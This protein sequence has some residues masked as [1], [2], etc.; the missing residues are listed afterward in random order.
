MEIRIVLDDCTWQAAF[1][2]RKHIVHKYSLSH[3]HRRLTRPLY[4]HTVLRH[5]D[6]IKFRIVIVDYRCLDAGKSARISS[7]TNCHRLKRRYYFVWTQRS[8]VRQRSIQF[9]YLFT[10][11][12]PPGKCAFI[13]VHQ[14]ITAIF[15]RY[16][17]SVATHSMQSVWRIVAR[18]HFP[19][20]LYVYLHRLLTP[21]KTAALYIIIS[22]NYLHYLIRRIDCLH[23]PRKHIEAQAV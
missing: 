9:I 15:H 7:L 11:C 12:C 22:G 20:H 2:I 10:R 14:T 17:V 1:A 8:A 23:L 16:Q 19:F 5:G 6:A 18:R 4:P 13:T 3:F 21:A